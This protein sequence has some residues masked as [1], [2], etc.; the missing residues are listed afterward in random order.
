MKQDP[1]KTFLNTL[2]TP[3]N[4]TLI[5]AIHQGYH[6]ITESILNKS[7]Q[8]SA[9]TQGVYL[10]PNYGYAVGYARGL[11][12]GA[13]SLPPESL[14]KGSIITLSIPIE[15]DHI[16]GDVWNSVKDDLLNDISNGDIETSNGILLDLL[17]FD[18]NNITNEDKEYLIKNID[19]LIDTM[20]IYEWIDWQ[21][22][23]MGYSEI[24]LDKINPKYIV[25]IDIYENGEIINT[26]EKNSPNDDEVILYHGTPRTNF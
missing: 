6:T 26:I 17:G 24:V 21:E 13:R 3:T 7:H 1:F 14:E 16:G 19:S 15:I 4:T 11:K 2:R 10:T 12:G 5:E 8:I 25:K 20:N 18:P 22:H 9:S 23:S